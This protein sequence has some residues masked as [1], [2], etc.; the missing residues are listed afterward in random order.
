MG[1]M[2]GEYSNKILEAEE[3]EDYRL[4]VAIQSDPGF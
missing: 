1:K 2:F 3:E 4:S